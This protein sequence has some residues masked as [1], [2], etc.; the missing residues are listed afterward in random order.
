MRKPHRP[1]APSRVK[2]VAGAKGVANRAVAEGKVAAAKAAANDVAVKVAVEVVRAEAVAMAVDRKVAEAIEVES[3]PAAAT[4]R[5]AIVLR[6]DTT[7][8]EALRSS[9]P[10]A[11][12]HNQSTGTTSPGISRLSNPAK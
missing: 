1:A 7:K 11:K 12:Q 5:D 10:H 9:L 2:V 6:A 4:I 3:L 8:S